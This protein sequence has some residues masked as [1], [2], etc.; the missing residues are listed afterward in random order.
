MFFERTGSSELGN[1]FS[2]TI[3]PLPPPAAPHRTHTHAHNI[4]TPHSH[5]T[6]ITFTPRYHHLDNSQHHHSHCRSHLVDTTHTAL[7]PH[8]QQ[9]HRSSHIPS[10]FIYPHTF[11]YFRTFTH[12]PSHANP[13]IPS[14]ISSHIHRHTQCHIFSN[15]SF[16]ILARIFSKHRKSLKK[17]IS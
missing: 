2:L 12:I 17:K 3:P 14:N 16:P 1:V 13:H 5:H 10:H 7:T 4:L 6:H 11:T 15:I 9:T 8:S